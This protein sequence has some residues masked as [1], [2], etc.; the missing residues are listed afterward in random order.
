MQI[1]MSALQRAIALINQAMINAENDWQEAVDPKL[2]AYYHGK[3]NAF[4]TA[5]E[6]LS[7]ESEVAYDPA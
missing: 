3:A 1:S 5:L 2:A 7:S 4:S 6:L